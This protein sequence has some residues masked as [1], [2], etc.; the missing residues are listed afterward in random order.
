MEGEGGRRRGRTAQE[1]AGPLQ[2]AVDDIKLRCVVQHAHR[3]LQD[4]AA[5]IL[6]EAGVPQS[7]WHRRDQTARHL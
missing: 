7:L 1:E 4:V 2:V 5:A 3:R 6:V